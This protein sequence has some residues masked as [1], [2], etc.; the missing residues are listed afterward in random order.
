MLGFRG[1]SKTFSRGYQVKST[2]FKTIPVYPAV[3]SPSNHNLL[4]SLSKQELDKKL[5]PEGWRRSLISSHNKER[6][7]AGDVVRV[8]YNQQKCKY[9]NLMGYVLSVDR[10]ALEQDAS[11]LLR[12]QYS[13]TFV[14]VRVPIFSPL[15]E[16]IDLIRRADGRRQRSKHYYI[17]GTKL[18][19]G[20]LEAGMRKRR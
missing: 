17:R 9:D 19:V 2:T 1:F 4:S 10:K 6:L 5:D 12:N 11:I 7:R 20:D 18:D 15:V 3:Q 13:K 14:E 16:R 8:A